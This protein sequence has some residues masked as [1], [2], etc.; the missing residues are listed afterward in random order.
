MIVFEQSKAYT[1]IWIHNNTQLKAM[2][3][4][5]IGRRRTERIFS[6]FLLQ[7]GNTIMH[8]ID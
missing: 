6:L 3:V 5:T 2:I 4:W 7:S 1:M 8:I